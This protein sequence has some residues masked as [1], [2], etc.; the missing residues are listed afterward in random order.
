MIFVLFSNVNVEMVGE[1]K[2]ELGGLLEILPPVEF[3][4]IYGSKLHPNNKDE[5]FFYFFCPCWDRCDFG[6][7]V[8]VFT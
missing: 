1:D 2:A 7:F 8:K 4:C 3:C 5:V 6:S